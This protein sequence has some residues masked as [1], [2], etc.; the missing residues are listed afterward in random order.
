[1]GKKNLANVTAIMPTTPLSSSGDCI[2]P[3]NLHECNAASKQKLPQL[4]HF[5]QQK[6]ITTIVIRVY[7]VFVYNMLQ[8]KMTNTNTKHPAIFVNA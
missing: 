5:T 1:M 7:E 4:G 2:E 6:A 8:K 3:N